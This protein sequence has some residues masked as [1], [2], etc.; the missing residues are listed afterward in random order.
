MNARCTQCVHVGSHK[1][2]LPK[3]VIIHAIKVQ[4][5]PTPPPPCKSTDRLWQA[6]IMQSQRL[7]CD[8]QR[9]HTH[10]R[11]TNTTL[12]LERLDSHLT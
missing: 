6:H 9:T 2:K 8:N 12:K 7:S 3:T 1:L 5:P 10:T 4:P 11:Q